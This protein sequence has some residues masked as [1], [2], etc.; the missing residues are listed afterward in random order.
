MTRSYIRHAATVASIIVL[1]IL[2]GCTRH[3][4]H[5]EHGDD[6]DAHDAEMHVTVAEAQGSE[7]HEELPE[8]IVELSME[9]AEQAGIMYGS[10]ERESIG[11]SIHV[12]GTVRAV[13]QATA[14]VSMPFGGFI[15]S[16]NLLPGAAVR[17][18]QILATI[19][20]TEFVDL[21]QNYLD[22]KHRYAY[23][24]SE[25]QRHQSLYKDDVYSQKNV[26]QTTAEYLS[27]K[28]Q[29]RGLE[30]KLSVLGLDPKSLTED[31]I[32]A[33]IPLRAPITGN[34]ASS[35]VNI[36]KYVAPTDV[37]FTIANNNHLMLELTLFE[38]DVQN[39]KAESAVHFTVNNE[40]H[41]HSA[42]IYQVGSSI[43]ANRT[44]T[45]F[46]TVRPPCRNILPGMYIDATIEQT[47]RSAYVVPKESVVSFNDSSYVFVVEREK[48]ENGKPYIEY[49]FV[50]VKAGATRDGK[51]EVIPLDAAQLQKAKLVVKGAYTL[52]SA[53]KNAGEMTC[54]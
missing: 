13:P 11:G 24:E 40:Q 32:T 31:R 17:K 12:N 23:L 42:V 29:L 53:K 35:N 37:L 46:A 34:I 19:E 49:R 26:Q 3:N 36:G 20:N 2:T 10:L 54:G 45:A 5:A 21:Q 43:S 38:N 30:Q 1:L 39:V 27:L 4:S 47:S 16:T 41:E 28:T 33:V 52:L 9:Q 18:G 48:M 44:Y 7:E 50:K 51:I 25:Y 14:S 8:G 22:T 15:K 6:H